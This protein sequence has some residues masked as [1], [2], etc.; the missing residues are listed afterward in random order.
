MWNPWLTTEP[1]SGRF[2]DYPMCHALQLWFL[3]EWEWVRRFAV[4][5]ADQL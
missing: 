4:T 5:T 2:D 3:A 1:R